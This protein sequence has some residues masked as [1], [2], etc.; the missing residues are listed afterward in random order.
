MG[1]IE[2]HGSGKSEFISTEHIVHVRTQKSRFSG[3]DIIVTTPGCVF[4]YQTDDLDSHP[5]WKY[6]KENIIERKR[7]T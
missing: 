2:I 4:I 7:D 5:I 1:F 6:V 3:F